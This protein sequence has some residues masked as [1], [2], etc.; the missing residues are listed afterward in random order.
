M[1]EETDFVVFSVQLNPSVNR[2]EMGCLC[3]KL[4]T[5]N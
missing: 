4:K 3:R 1:G 5:E 2:K